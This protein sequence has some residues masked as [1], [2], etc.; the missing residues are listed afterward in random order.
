[1]AIERED[2]ERLVLELLATQVRESQRRR[3]QPASQAMPALTIN[4]Q[5]D[6]WKRV[7]KEGLA[8]PRTPPGTWHR[9][10]NRIAA[11]I[12]W[13]LAIQRV[14]T[15]GADLGEARLPNFTVTPYGET[16]LTQLQPSLYDPDGYLAH[17][18]ALC[19]GLDP[20]INEYV[21]EGLACMRGGLV[22]AAAV[23]F[24]AASEKAILLLLKSIGD[25]ERDAKAKTE[26][27]RLLDHRGL[28]S[29]LKL[30]QDRIKS[31]TE[32]KSPQMPYTV[33]QGCTEHLLS[34]LE[35]IRVHRN[36][37]VHPEA[38]KCSREKVFLT[39][40]AFPGALE[41]VYRLIDWFSNNKI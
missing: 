5:E 12:L 9:A 1:M 41:V 26:I 32:G 38:A 16:I 14:L 23:M 27:E 37:S 34:L 6:L 18:S 17:I 8:P 13:D 39:I 24:G 15:E 11:D 29:I 19:P 40:Q 10:V 28:P 4:L 21:K 3:A 20:V 7:E 35:M 36:D 25:A 2:I 31:L 30:I 22:F 33:H